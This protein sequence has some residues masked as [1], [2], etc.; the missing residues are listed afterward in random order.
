V[1]ILTAKSS[2]SAMAPNFGEIHGRS[3][4]DDTAYPQIEAD[5]TL[6]KIP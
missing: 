4:F 2:F 5:I 6:V 1:G 3:H